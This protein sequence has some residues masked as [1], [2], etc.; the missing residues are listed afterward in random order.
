TSVYRAIGSMGCPVSADR[1]RAA[2]MRRMADSP[3]LT[4]AMRLHTR[5]L[6]PAQARARSGG[7]A[8]SVWVS[9]PRHDA[10][11]HSVWELLARIFAEP[12]RSRSPDTAEPP[13]RRRDPLRTR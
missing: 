8:G 5:R 1:S 13:G 9:L 3:R 7:V 11:M 4:M 6:L 12:V 2:W 10:K